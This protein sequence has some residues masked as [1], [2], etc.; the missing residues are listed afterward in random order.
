MG[1][2][3]LTGRS[4]C[5]T[6]MLIWL[7]LS[8]GCASSGP[9]F[10]SKWAMDDARYADRFSGPYSK[11]P[12]NKLLRQG[13]EIIDARFQEG[14]SGLYTVAGIATR[15]RA[16]AV[17]EV[18]MTWLPTSWSTMRIGVEGMLA[19]GLPTYLTGG[20]VGIRLHSPTRFSPYVG[21]AGMAGVADTSTT[22]QS[23]Y[24]D[25]QGNIV[26]EGDRVPG[27]TKGL[28]A[29]IPEVGLSYWFTSRVRL[30][31]GASYYMTTDAGSGSTNKDF[32]LTTM[33]LDWLFSRE[34]EIQNWR[35]PPSSPQQTDTTEGDEPKPYFVTEDKREAP[36]KDIPDADTDVEPS[37]I[38]PDSIDELRESE[39]QA[40]TESEPWDQSL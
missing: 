13:E 29:I 20:I 38:L 14:R 37:A 31:V 34:S 30:N 4:F 1:I 5:A 19:D 12:L 22:A 16:A 32:V 7:S 39:P 15:Q 6:L 9:F 23:S 3:R 8:S 36:E 35:D 25:K 40:P 21:V 11:R 28:A 26:Q 24:I 27:V 2:G 18:G 33:S 17:G 10:S